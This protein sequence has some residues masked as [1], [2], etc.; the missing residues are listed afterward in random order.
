MLPDEKTTC[1][2]TM[3]ADKC[4]DHFEHC[5]KWVSIQGAHPQTGEIINN[6]GCS[7]SFIPL[8]LVEN[9]NMQRGTQAAIESF[10]NEVLEGAS[11]IANSQ[12]RHISPA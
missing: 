7:D 9:S 1:P 12:R 11:A 4:R 6:T 10:R 5:P 2:A 3:H 8:L